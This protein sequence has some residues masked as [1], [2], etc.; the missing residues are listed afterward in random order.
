MLA[1]HW[2]FFDLTITTP[3]LTMRYPSDDDLEALA[4]LT[5]EAVHA[6]DFMPFSIPWTR[7]EPPERQW[8]ALRHW[9]RQ[10]ASL[11]VDDWVLPFVVF[12]DGEAVGIQDVGAKQFPVTRSVVTGS[13]LVQR[14]QG[15]GIGKEMRSAVL[16]LAFD[17]LGAE[18]AHTSAFA[19]NAKSLGVTRSLGYRD[20]GAQIDEREGKAVNHLRFVM[21]RAEWERRRRDDIRVENLEPCLPLLG[22]AESPTPVDPTP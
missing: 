17:G 15:R 4:D 18:E 5:L 16:H 12:D 22:L 10:R 6:P 13:W 21:S 19:D 3:R 1:R 14:A 2:P 20:N 8:N 7:P 9:W 11:T